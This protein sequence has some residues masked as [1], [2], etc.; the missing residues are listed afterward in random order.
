MNRNQLAVFHAVVREGGFGKAA[1]SL[2]ISQPAVSF[3][4][5][6]LEEALGL[7]LFDRVGR[8]ARLTEAG[9][10]LYDYARRIGDIEKEATEAMERLAS[11]KAGKLRIGA[12]STIGAYLLPQL[13]KD[14]RKNWPG[15]ELEMTL[16]NTAIVQQQLLDGLVDLALVEGR[17][18][19]P[20]LTQLVFR[21][22]QLVPVAATSHP[23]LK[24]KRVSLTDFLKYPLILR[25]EGSGTR[26]VILRYLAE[27]KQAYLGAQ[28]FGSTE[29]V[30]GAV[31]AGL[32]V[33][34][35][36]SLTI[37][38]DVMLRRLEVVDLAKDKV[39]RRPFYVLQMPGKTKL[40]AVTAFL[41][42]LKKR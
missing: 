41:S 29:A 42:I 3:Q 40:P 37:P 39:I 20:S 27:K 23:L 28:T 1:V 35:V 31:A 30:K 26:D 25:E 7:R 34:F 5:S 16:S 13:F 17:N 15:V 11:V 24:M 14:Y 33:S 9:Q 19:D 12:S 18:L 38:G 4:I 2:R 36:S 6:Q 8:E 10:I 22:D 21:E 32:G